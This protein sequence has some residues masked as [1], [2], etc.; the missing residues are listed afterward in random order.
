MCQSN[1]NLNLPPPPSW[2][3]MG[4]LLLSVPRGGREF[5]SV[6]GGGGQGIWTLP[7]WDISTKSVKTFQCSAHL[8]MEELRDQESCLVI[9][10]LRKKISTSEYNAYQQKTQQQHQKS[11]CDFAKFFN[12]H[13]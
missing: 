11:I 13:W 9:K 6:P 10:W 12:I 2:Q 1:Q 7:R 8:L 4:I 5:L 3:P